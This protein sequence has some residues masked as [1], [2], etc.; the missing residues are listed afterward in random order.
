ME[1]RICLCPS[2]LLSF[3]F[4]LLESLHCYLW[5]PTSKNRVGIGLFW[6][7]FDSPVTQSNLST[8]AA[9]LPLYVQIWGGPRWVTVG[10]SNT[11][12]GYLF[13]PSLL[14]LTHRTNT[15]QWTYLFTSHF[16]ILAS[17]AATIQSIDALNDAWV[18]DIVVT[19]KV[20]LKLLTLDWV[21]LLVLDRGQ[22]HFPYTVSWS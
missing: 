9:R 7:N 13:L 16:L 12:T 20:F 22:C 3:H 1:A 18:H 2:S 5:S 17:H 8:C 15:F 14:C 19:I 10:G 4:L 21:V 6:D 11:S